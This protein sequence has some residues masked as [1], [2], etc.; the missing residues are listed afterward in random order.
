MNAREAFL[1][2]TEGKRVL[3]AHIRRNH[4]DETYAY[5]LKCGYTQEELKLFLEMID[6]DYSEEVLSNE[7]MGLIWFID[8]TW[9]EYIE[10][11]GFFTWKWFYPPEIYK[12][13]LP[14]LGS[15]LYL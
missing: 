4:E 7:I 2:A 10:H 3:C 1:K 9:A 5:T 15:N 11:R 12:D 8:K 6:F 14:T 13:C